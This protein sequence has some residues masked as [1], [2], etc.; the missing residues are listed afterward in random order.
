M[1][2]LK[3]IFLHLF[4]C[5]SIFLLVLHW[6]YSWE[7][8]WCLMYILCKFHTFCGYLF[9]IFSCFPEFLVFFMVFRILEKYQMFEIFLTINLWWL[10]TF[11]YV[12]FFLKLIL[13]WKLTFYHFLIFPVVWAFQLSVNL[14]SGKG[15]LNSYW[16]NPHLPNCTWFKPKKR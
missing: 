8:I 11:T 12:T 15:L 5:T 3:V 1:I 2:A 4:Q 13:L 6:W 7:V 10:N 9:Q 16:V 14:R